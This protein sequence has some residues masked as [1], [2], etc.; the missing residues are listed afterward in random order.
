MRRDQYTF[1]W[2][3]F[4]GV[5]AAVYD[6]VQR[7]TKGPG[8]ADGMQKLIN[9]TK[10][11]VKWNVDADRPLVALA[12]RVEGLCLVA[13]AEVEIRVIQEKC[14]CMEAHLKMLVSLRLIHWLVY[15]AVRPPSGDFSRRFLS[16]ED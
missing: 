4:D 3:V 15:G 2:H 1:Y 16:R 5:E 9:I 12:D 13:A 6:I 8:S 14:R 10:H 11:R 7:V